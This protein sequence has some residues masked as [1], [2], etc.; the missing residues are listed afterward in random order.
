MIGR[1]LC[2]IIANKIANE[3]KKSF[4][5]SNYPPQ[6]AKQK[7]DAIDFDEKKDL[8]KKMNEWQEEQYIQQQIIQSF[9]QHYYN[10]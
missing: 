9:L 6:D 5:R 8:I 10:R 2:E 7:C 3:Y 1:Y 4:I